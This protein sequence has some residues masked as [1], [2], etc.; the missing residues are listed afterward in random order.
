MTTF[1]LWFVAAVIFLLGMR[2]GMAVEHAKRPRR[3]TVLVGVI[4]RTPK[5]QP[6]LSEQY[7]SPLADPHTRRVR[8]EA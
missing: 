6:D 1:L 2:F 7:R 4:H 5:A 3:S 8:M